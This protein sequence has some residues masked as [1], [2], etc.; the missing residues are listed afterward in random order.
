MNIGRY[1]D[2]FRIVPPSHHVFSMAMALLDDVALA[3]GKDVSL[4]LFSPP[5]EGVGVASQKNNG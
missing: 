5:L 3:F 1:S 2:L 4:Y